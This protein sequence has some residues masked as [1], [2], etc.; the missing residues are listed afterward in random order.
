MFVFLQSQFDQSDPEMQQYR[1]R[2]KARKELM[3]YAKFSDFDEGGLT[4]IHVG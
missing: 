3:Q 4:D 2:V 1:S